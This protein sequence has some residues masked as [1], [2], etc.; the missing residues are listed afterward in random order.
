[1]SGTAGLQLDNLQLQ[2]QMLH[3]KDSYSLNTLSKISRGPRGKWTVEVSY[4]SRKAAFTAIGGLKKNSA[5]LDLDLAWDKERDDSA[6]VSS[7]FPG[8]D[9]DGL[10]R[11][12]AVLHII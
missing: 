4:P 3:G 5:D 12:N 2:G 1:M 6:K 8:I 9:D 11:T 10:T 7:F